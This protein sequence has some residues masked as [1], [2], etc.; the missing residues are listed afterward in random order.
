VASYRSAASTAF[1]TAA[2][3]S[4]PPRSGGLT[5]PAKVRSTAASMRSA[6]AEHNGVGVAA[7]FYGALGQRLAGVAIMPGAGR[8]LGEAEFQSRRRRLDPAQHFE[9]RRHDFGADAV[10]GN[11]RNVEAVVGAHDVSLPQIN[12][13]QAGESI[14]AMAARLV[15]DT[16]TI[17]SV[18]TDTVTIGSVR[19]ASRSR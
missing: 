6:G 10:A 4:R 12:Q 5:P 14:E 16:A 7:E 9:R 8:R 13:R 18:T 1:A 17:G 11:R 15:S 19:W 2:V 3:P